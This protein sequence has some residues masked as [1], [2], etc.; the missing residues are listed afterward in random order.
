MSVYG[1]NRTVRGS[2]ALSKQEKQ[3]IRRFAKLHGLTFSAYVRMCATA[4][5]IERVS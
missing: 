4:D 2:L 3:T 1:E 5:P